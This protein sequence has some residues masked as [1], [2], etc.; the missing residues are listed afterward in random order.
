[1]AGGGEREG[2]L[3]R[4]SKGGIGRESEGGRETGGGKES[5]ANLPTLETQSAFGAGEKST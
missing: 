4:E 3:G 5:E 1:M 2:E